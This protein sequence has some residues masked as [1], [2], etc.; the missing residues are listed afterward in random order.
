MP[1]I[2]HPSSH[3]TT[4]TNDGSVPNPSPTDTGPNNPDPNGT[5]N[6]STQDED[7]NQ[8]A[9]ASLFGTDNNEIAT[10]YLAIIGVGVC[11]FFTCIIFCLYKRK[12]DRQL[13]MVQHDMNTMKQKQATDKID[14]LKASNGPNLSPRGLNPL[15]SHHA[16]PSTSTASNMTAPSAS[17][18]I[19]VAGPALP[20]C[21]TDTNMAV[22]GE[23]NSVFI[24]NQSIPPGMAAD[25]SSDVAEAAEYVNA[26]AA[27]PPR[28]P[29]VVDMVGTTPM[30]A[31]PDTSPRVPPPVP[32]V[33]QNETPPPP[34]PPPAPQE[35]DDDD[36]DEMDVMI[37]RGFTKDG[38]GGFE[39]SDD[40]D[41]DIVEGTKRNLVP[42]SK[43]YTPGENYEE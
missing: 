1:I 32:P 23:N 34:L 6:G 3:S 36:Y 9:L 21:D 15:G 42:G 22:S 13:R 12:S 7:E 39:E 30:G 20:H 10:L 16:L 24:K 28:V 41:D 18:H 5:D 33:P 43:G 35:I 11:L 40:D 25:A 31:L 26:M 8:S 2:Q 17:M 29:A 4:V 38:H 14:T 37:D 19:A 27:L